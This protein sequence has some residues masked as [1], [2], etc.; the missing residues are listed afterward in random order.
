MENC[1]FIAAHFNKLLIFLIFRFTEIPSKEKTYLRTPMCVKSTG[2]RFSPHLTYEKLPVYFSLALL[3][4]L[5]LLPFTVMIVYFLE[6]GNIWH[7]WCLHHCFRHR[8]AIINNKCGPPI[9]KILC[10]VC[11]TIASEIYICLKI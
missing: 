10:D 2:R 8:P 5:I 4:N 3:M 7:H 9:L 11:S 1:N 6:L